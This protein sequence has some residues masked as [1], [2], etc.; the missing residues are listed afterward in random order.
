M[1]N[2]NNPIVQNQELI[3][4][5]TLHTEALQ[6]LLVKKGIVTDKEVMDEIR[7]IQKE[8]QDKLD[9]ASKKN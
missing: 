2:K 7:Q 3:Y 9:D 6:R 8:V 4:A 1:D 5:N